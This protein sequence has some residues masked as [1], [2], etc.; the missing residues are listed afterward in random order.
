MS[1]PAVITLVDASNYKSKFRRFVVEDN[2]GEAIHLHIDN[3]RIDFTVQEYL[4]FT[5]MIKCA[6]N[7]LEI[8]PGF[9]LESFDEHFLKECAPYLSKLQKISIEGVKLSRLSCI[10]HSKYGSKRN[11]L[12]LVPIH[13]TPAFKYLEGKTAAFKSYEQF[14]Y[15]N[16][17]NE[18]RLLK[19]FESIKRNG[20]P[21]NDQ[22]IVL[23]NGQDIVRDGQH[24]AAILAHLYGLDFKAKVVCFHFS[25]RN[26]LMKIKKE[27]LIT[28]LRQLKLGA[29]TVARKVK[30]TL[31]RN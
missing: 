10:V 29:L 2:I 30:R 9:G 4:D 31:R 13:K 6:L 5:S 11:S 20:Y 19:T 25:G 27:N 8:L 7:E 23:F 24:R 12:K 1:N 28:S 21:F 15:F 18:S 22:H 17:S 16:V 14:N 26:H 3:M